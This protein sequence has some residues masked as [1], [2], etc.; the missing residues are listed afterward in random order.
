M[1]K[2]LTVVAGFVF[3]AIVAAC[4][5]GGSPS[6]PASGAHTAPDSMADK[7][8]LQAS[9]ADTSAQAQACS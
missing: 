5:V 8:K 9:W 1:S 6:T 7:A 3:A 4:S 2:A